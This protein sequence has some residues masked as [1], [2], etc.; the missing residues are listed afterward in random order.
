MA[1]PESFGDCQQ[2]KTMRSEAA[3]HADFSGIR[4]AQCWEDADVLLAALE[5]G[6][7]KRCLSIASAGDNTLA[8][9]ARNPEY[10]LA[11]DLS[12]AQL[13]CLELRVAA[14]R[15]LEHRELLALIGSNPSQNRIKLYRRCRDYLSAAAAQF[16]DDIFA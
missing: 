13:A 5:P 16:W 7:G 14:Y 3:E 6:P 12:A 8:L 11:I 1:P 9:L 15:A 4:Y 2:E 10:V